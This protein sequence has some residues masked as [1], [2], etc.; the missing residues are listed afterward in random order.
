MSRS[1]T[2]GGI[3][4]LLPPVLHRGQRHRRPSLP[5]SLPTHPHHQRPVSHPILGL[6]LEATTQA[7]GRSHHQPRPHAQAKHEGLALEGRGGRE[8][9][10]GRWGWAYCRL[11]L[12]CL[13]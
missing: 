13:V 7:H 10:A 3:F 12:L 11:I 5:P 8:G 1:C 9:G 4:A 2:C 6:G